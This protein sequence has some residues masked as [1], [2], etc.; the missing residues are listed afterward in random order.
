ML[1]ANKHVHFFFTA[2]LLSCNTFKSLCYVVSKPSA[3]KI[4]KIVYYLF[5]ENIFLNSVRYNNQIN[6]IKPNG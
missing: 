1:P 6:L 4:K 2:R 3:L 5:L